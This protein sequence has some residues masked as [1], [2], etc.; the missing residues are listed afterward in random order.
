MYLGEKV[1]PAAPFFCM[2]YVKCLSKSLYSKKPATPRKITGCVH[3]TLMLTFHS[4]IHLNISVFAMLL[5]YRKLIHDS[6]SLMFWKPRIVCLVLFWRTYKFGIIIF[7][8]VVL[9]NIKIFYFFYNNVV[10]KMQTIF[11]TNKIK[12]NNYNKTWDYTNTIPITAR[13]SLGLNTK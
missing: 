4:N 8:S 7:V 13:G 2:S 12:R 1:F 10:H 11:T 6:I 3:V 9:K 5:I